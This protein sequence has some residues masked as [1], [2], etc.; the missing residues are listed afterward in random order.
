LASAERIAHVVLEEGNRPRS[1]RW[2]A[3]A[4]NERVLRVAEAETSHVLPATRL[5]V[6]WSGDEKAALRAQA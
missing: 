4:R 5:L 3:A 6:S 1:G 2:S